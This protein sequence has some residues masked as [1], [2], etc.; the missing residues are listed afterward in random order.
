MKRSTAVMTVVGAGLL[1]LSSGCAVRQYTVVKDRID[2]DLQN[3]NRGYV[4]GRMLKEVQETPRKSSRQTYVTE[5]ELPALR[6]F[7]KKSKAMPQTQAQTPQTSDKSS[8]VS[9]A[10]PK[11][12]EQTME[13]TPVLGHETMVR[14]TVSKEDTLQKISLKFYGTTKKWGK[15]YNANKETLKAADRIYHGQTLN[16]PIEKLKEPQENLK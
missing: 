7:W 6:P 11:T 5:I 4:K 13:N 2:Q 3:G 8:D 14:Y 9:L 16:I 15:I 12:R 10:K 1:L